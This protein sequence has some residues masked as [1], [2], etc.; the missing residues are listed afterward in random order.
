VNANISN[1]TITNSTI[2]NST[3]T[4]SI[5]NNSVKINS[6]IINSVIVNSNN[7]NSTIINSNETNST[8]I[9]STVINSTILNSFKNGS[10]INNSIITNSSLIGCIVINSTII[11]SIK[12]NCTIINS[13]IIGSNNT[14]TTV[15]NSTERNSTDDDTFVINSSIILSTKLGDII[16]ASNLTDSN[17]TASNITNSSI[18]NSSVSNSTLT[19][20]TVI[21]S[22]IEDATFDGCSFIDTIY[23]LIF[24][25]NITTSA[26]SGSTT[27]GT[28][29][30]YTITI[31]NN[32]TI[33]ATY[34][35]TVQN[36]DNAST[37]TL[38]AYN[39]T[40]A[41]NS[42]GTVTL[43]VTDAS[44]ASV[45]TVTVT[46]FLST[47]D[48][49]NATT[50]VISTTVNPAPAG[51]GGGGGGGCNEA[52]ACGAWDT[53]FNS[54]Q[55]RT[56]VDSNGCGTTDNKP[57]EIQSCS[58]C[59]PNWLCD[60]W[61]DC[62][63]GI[64]TRDCIDANGCGSF[65]GQPALSQGC[66]ESPEVQ[67]PALLGNTAVRCAFLN[68]TLATNFRVERSGVNITSLIPQGYALAAPPFTLNCAG[69]VAL[70]LQASDR[71]TDF[72][73]LHCNKNTC[74]LERISEVN[75]TAL[76]CGNRTLRSRTTSGSS[77]ETGVISPAQL[78]TAVSEFKPLTSS[79]DTI[80]LRNYAF[81]AEGVK[82]RLAGL[83]YPLP[84]PKNQNLAILGTPLIVEFTDTLTRRV[85]G[86]V[87]LPVPQAK[88]IEPGSV[89]VYAF[90][91]STWTPVGGTQEGSSISVHIYDLR[92][93]LVNKKLTLA[94]VGVTCTACETAAF[95]REYSSPGTRTAIVLVHGA[96]SN[97]DTYNFMIDDFRAT[98][99][100]FDVWTYDYPSNSSLDSL[101]TNLADAML[102]QA[103]RYDQFYIVGHSAGGLI[104]QQALATA[105]QRG[106][107]TIPKVRRVVLVGSPTG[108]APSIEVLSNL[109][110]NIL[111]QR[112]VRLFNLNSQLIQATVEG[113]DIPR[114]PGI[115]YQVIAGTHPYDF[116]L[117]LFQFSSQQFL[118][119]TM[120]NDG[121]IT[122]QSAQKVG[123][124]RVNDLCKDYYEIN[125]THTDL[126]DNDIS[127]RIVE[128]IITDD[129]GGSTAE[130]P[131]LGQDQY[132][133][134]TVP[135]CVSGDQYALIGKP[136]S[137]KERYDPSGC[138]CGNGV[139]GV[140]ENEQNC[141][142]DCARIYTFEKFCFATPLALTLLLLA[143][144]TA[145]ATFGIRHYLTKRKVNI[146]WL[147]AGS[148]TVLVTLFLLGYL[149][150]VCKFTNLLM[151]AAL[152]LAAYFIAAIFVEKFHKHTVIGPPIVMPKPKKMPE[153]REPLLKNV[154]KLL[155]R[156]KP[157]GSKATKEYLADL[158]RELER[159][160]KDLKERKKYR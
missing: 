86:T 29:A 130:H 47:N 139:C 135:D 103:N 93:Y 104:V 109:L 94:T 67:E 157:E 36:L 114:V 133:Q 81:S 11:D 72:K 4:N 137:D 45:F 30:T 35:L 46:A 79:D 17:V 89:Q 84:Y 19:N 20:C 120:K 99:Q 49:L 119:D 28:P 159:I 22:T 111:T 129:V 27:V 131:L 136:I 92:P 71:F 85:A 53:C 108:G 62:D 101:S 3:V 83:S 7:S 8:D 40:V 132:V 68:R 123:S 9:G 148:A 140:G 150:H 146:R 87:T 32:G 155:R 69:T 18:I 26:T 145:A 55:T 153:L 38:S 141:P 73:V 160:R 64:Q 44:N 37:A 110:N 127:I 82:V 6:T 78:S 134:V 59:N 149:S 41:P 90:V 56:C 15:L 88:G 122:I 75:L 51:G 107:S 76:K 60:D 124:S 34:N 13:V 154:K 31:G 74:A 42:V 66:T 121:V 98:Q 116:N 54:I 102:L 158:N 24:G 117:G 58:A 126:I 63:N 65:T 23:P 2:I 80:T 10:Q 113:K 112:A 5:I 96:F 156:R 70:T 115:D 151:V 138:A 97:K 147:Y 14:N 77:T 25:V 16:N 152:L 118:Q 52:W 12:S 33:T 144:T 21:N 128:R 43:S 95:E 50:A 61:S 106:D 48:T 142:S 57:S 1:S 39:I 125:L 100:P 105:W 143:L 91:N